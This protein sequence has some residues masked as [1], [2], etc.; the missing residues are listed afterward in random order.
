MV[1]MVMFELL[2]TRISPSLWSYVR[3]RLCR[4][5]LE[6]IT[7]ETKRRALSPLNPTIIRRMPGAVVKL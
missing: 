6:D 1:P 3:R 4:E 7:I 2:H 5:Q